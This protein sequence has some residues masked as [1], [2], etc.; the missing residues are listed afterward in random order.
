MSEKAALPGWLR[1]ANKVIIA[2]QRLGIVIG[3][4][5][6]L[7][8]PGRVTGELRTTPVSP[9]TVDG[10]DYVIGGLSNADWVRNARKAGW[11]VV[12]AGRRKRTRVDMV[13]LPVEQRGVILAQFPSK[14]PHGVP[15]FQKIGVVEKG[16]PEEFEAAAD[17]C[18]VFRLENPRPWEG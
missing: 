17:R 6:V 7:S 11:G 10:Q 1:P 18:P 8:V 13:E 15:F 9:L 5:R 12:A 14:V 3:T 4:M 16:T 2:L